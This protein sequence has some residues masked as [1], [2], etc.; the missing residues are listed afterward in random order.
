MDRAAAGSRP[1][2]A[3]VYRAAGQVVVEDVP[4]ASISAQT[5]AVVRVLRSCVCGSDLWAYR[6][7]IQRA[8][9]SRLGHEFLGIVEEVGDQVT[10]VKPGDLVVA[11]FQ[12]SDNSCPLCQDGLQTA[13]L[14]GG[15]FGAPRTD[16]G[17]G[18]AVRVPEADGTLVPVPGGDEADDRLLTALLALTDVMATGLHATVLAGVKPGSTVAV[19]G[20]GAVGLC[21]VLGASRVLGAERIVLFSRNPGRQ[22]VGRSFGATDII[23]RRGEEG[24][25]AGRELAGGLG[26]LHVVEAVGSPE[27][28]EMVVAMARPGG[29]VGAVGVPHTT[30]SLPLFPLFVQ[31]LHV[32]LGIAP[33]RHYLPDLISRGNYTLTGEGRLH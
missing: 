18:Q 2:R 4:D 1:V 17:Q 3:A 30:P 11:P 29:A 33:V 21:A 12:W 20:D 9:G 8:E 15:T 16:G 5:D 19:V 31:Q 26:F 23:A 10:T 13:C 7:I 25:Q 6:G 32:S 24:V 22:S 14:N 28:W 27:A